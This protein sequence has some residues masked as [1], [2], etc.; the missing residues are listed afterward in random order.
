MEAFGPESITG[1]SIT[2]RGVVSRVDDGQRTL[3]GARSGDEDPAITDW[4]PEVAEIDRRRALA[5]QMGGPERVARQHAAGRLTIRER[6]DGLVDPG[7]FHEFGALVGSATYENGVMS[8]FTPEPYVGGLAKIDGR[9]VVVAGE[10]FTVRGGSAQGGV[11]GQR[12]KRHFAVQ[13]AEEYRVPFVQML[14]GVGA[15]VAAMDQLGRSYIPNSGDWSR[16]LGLLAKVPVIAGIAGAVAGGVAAYALLTHWNCMIEGSELFSAGP[17]VVKRAIGLDISKSDLGGTDVHVR[18]SGVADNLAT[19]ELD[20]FA[21]MRRFLSYLPQNVWELPPYEEPNDRPDR[22]E[23]A[24]L[25]IIPRQRKRAYSMHK[26]IGLVVDEGSFFEIKPLYAR[27]LIVGLARMHGHVVGVVANNPMVQGGALDVPG[28]EK[29]THFIEMCDY[30]RIPLINFADVPGFMVG[31]QAEAAGV[32]R[33]GMRALWIAHQITVP[34][35]TVQVRR[36]YGMAGVATSTPA[37]LGL[38]IGWPSGEWGSIPIEGGVEA[39]YRRVI[40]DA[41]DPDAKR[42]E[43]EDRLRL[44]K[45]V[46]PIAEAFGV[47]ELIDPR[48]TRHVIIRYLETAIPRLSHDLG[49]KPRYGVRP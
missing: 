47:E 44:M 34:L 22:R 14:D 10:D 35:V 38:R 48:D 46:F 18:Q 24:L 32:L 40:N 21:Q 27:S 26:L 33:S 25:S 7:S 1:H 29:M 30:F 31:P 49:P 20:C 37:R 11:P 39:A 16:N 36:C 19:D 3:G 28:S 43:I 15:N 17:P 41:A 12:S 9:P 4:S 42:A 23:E 6:I 2:D 45:S 8:G 13:M 5:M